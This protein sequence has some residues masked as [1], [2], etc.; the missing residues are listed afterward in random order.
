MNSDISMRRALFI[1][2]LFGISV[3]RCKIY[4]SAENDI[5]QWIDDVVGVIENATPTPV[6]P[7]AWVG[8]WR[9]SEYQ[10]IEYMP[11]SCNY[12]YFC[13]EGTLII[14]L[15]G[16]DVAVIKYNNYTLNVGLTDSSLIVIE[17]QSIDNIYGTKDHVSGRMTLV[18][19]VL[20]LHFHIVGA[21]DCAVDIFGASI[22]DT[23]TETLV[24]EKS[25]QNK[26]LRGDRILIVSTDGN[27]YAPDGRKW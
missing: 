16:T 7:T 24:I 14:T 12:T 18:E 13:T 11:Q 26:L 25:L 20:Y 15:L 3:G 17:G 6:N 8:T 1:V 5:L 27:T 2:F 19:G 9:I 23:S 4:A 22:T 10:R 21:Q